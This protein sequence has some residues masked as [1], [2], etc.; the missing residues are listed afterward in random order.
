[1][2]VKKDE[3]GDPVATLA[4]QWRLESGI[5]FLLRLLEAKYDGLYQSVTRQT[6]IT[7][8]QFGV[9]MALLQEGPMTASALAERISCDRNTLSEMLKRMTARRLISKKSHPGD[10]RSIQVQITAKGTSALMA[11]VPAAAR[12][13]D[14][15]LA[16]LSQ[17]DRA[18]FLRCML[19]IAKSPPPE[20][21]T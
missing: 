4:H 7:P 12:L 2:S 13:Q 11:V 21:D 3:A 9:L 16:P 10:R 5:G 1:M 18:H 17:D 8:R 6:D 15:M 19:A 14:L 20:S